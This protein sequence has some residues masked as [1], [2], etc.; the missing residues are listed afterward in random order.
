MTNIRYVRGQAQIQACVSSPQEP[1]CKEGWQI[2]GSGC[3]EHQ[4]RH[5]SISPPH[6]LQVSSQTPTSSIKSKTHHVKVKLGPCSSTP[7]SSCDT[8]FSIYNQVH[9]N[10]QRKLQNSTSDI[11]DHEGSIERQ[12]ELGLGWEGLVMS[13]DCVVQAV[14]SPPCSRVSHKPNTPHLISTELSP[15][16]PLQ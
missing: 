2:R 1:P 11:T 12:F 16:C 10:H 6:P 13:G 3:C 9:C 8:R 5:T 7:T 14:A 4:V 15:A